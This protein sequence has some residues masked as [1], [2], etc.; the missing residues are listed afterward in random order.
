MWIGG[1]QILE[2]LKN[3]PLR[4]SELKN[5]VP[6]YGSAFDIVLSQLM[7]IGLVKKYERDGEEYVELTD[8]G[9]SY[10]YAYYGPAYHHGPWHHHGY[11]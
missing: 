8:L 10:P 4:I 6:L 5:K 3:G 1:Y 7:I 11:W 9:K 2:S